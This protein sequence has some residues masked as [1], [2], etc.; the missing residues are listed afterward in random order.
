MYLQQM[1]ADNWTI[2]PSSFAFQFIFRPPEDLVGSL[3]Q[4]WSMP[5]VNDF[6]VVLRQNVY[7]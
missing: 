6:V 7:G 4:S 3:A 5:D 1:D 2:N